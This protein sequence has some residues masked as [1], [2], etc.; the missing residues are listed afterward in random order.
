MCEINNLIVWKT[1]SL[2]CYENNCLFIYLFIFLLLHM[3]NYY[4]DKKVIIH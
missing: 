3:N 1:R 2:A 4:I